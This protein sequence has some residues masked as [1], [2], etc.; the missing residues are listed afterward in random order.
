MMVAMR[1]R[2]LEFSKPCVCDEI[3]ICQQVFSD[4]QQN[5]QYSLDMDIYFSSQRRYSTYCTWTKMLS[6]SH[7]S[8]LAETSG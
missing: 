7:L 4:G 5:K 6:C 1:S 3:V 8:S 2:R